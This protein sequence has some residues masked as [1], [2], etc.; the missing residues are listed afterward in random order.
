[1]DCLRPCGSRSSDGAQ[2]GLASQEWLRQYGQSMLI[3]RF[4][5]SR[6]S[7]RS[8]KARGASR[9][10]LSLISLGLPL[11]ALAQALKSCGSDDDGGGGECEPGAVKACPVPGQSCTDGTQTCSE[12]GTYSTC[13][14]GGS[15]T[16]GAGGTGGAG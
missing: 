9:P 6:S 3:R 8:G 5:S 2:L 15:G 12:S 10:L 1:M 13:A 11:L 7:T 4:R 14:C 16:A